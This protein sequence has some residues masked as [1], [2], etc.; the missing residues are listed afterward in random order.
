MC[1]LCCKNFYVAVTR[2]I[3]RRK[4]YFGGCEQINIISFSKTILYASHNNAIPIN[5]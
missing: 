4:P 5:I 1:S 2:V 3:E